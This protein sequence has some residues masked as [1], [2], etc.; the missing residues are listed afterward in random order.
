MLSTRK[1]STTLVGVVLVVLL[2]AAVVGAALFLGYLRFEPAAAA[3][4]AAPTTGALVGLPAASNPATA[5]GEEV[6]VKVYEEVSPGV[7]YITNKSTRSTFF[8]VQQSV[9]SGS[10]FIIDNEGHVLTNYHVVRGAD[11]LQVVLADDTRVPAKVVGSDPANDIALLKIDVAADKLHV[12]PL[13]DSSKVKVGQLAIAIGNPFGL[14]RTVTTGVISSL[15]RSLPSSTGRAIRD[16]IQTDAAINPGNSG[17]PLLNA[18][19]EVI[20]I[21]TAIESPVEGSVGIGFAVPIN[22]AKAV[23]ADMKAG[24]TVE[25]AWLGITGTKVTS[26]LAQNLD[27][28]VDR[29]VYVLQVTRG[30]PA[31]NAGVRGTGVGVSNITDLDSI[32]RG[33]DVITAVDGKP[34]S[35]VEDIAA[36][37]D[38]KKPGDTVKLTIVRDKK[39]ME[40]EARLAKWPENL[41]AS[42]G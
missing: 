9:G 3:T 25:H 30:G 26:Q 41:R 13:G 15:G 17:G 8:G 35:S 6:V 28:G 23:L 1:V 5:S 16:M 31:A 12:V 4:S 39:Q 24:K 38:T 34:V 27:L 36:Y 2:V 7:V 10:G 33:G 14:E 32:P 42:G 22:S 40:L 21:N 18:Q 37:I 29:G 19:G 20:G 11:E